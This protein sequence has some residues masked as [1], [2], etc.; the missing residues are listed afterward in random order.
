VAGKSTRP[1]AAA[2][3]VW[4]CFWQLDRTRNGNGWSAFRLTH[5]D[6]LDWSTLRRRPLIAWEIDAL[7]A[8]DRAR[9]ETMEEPEKALEPLRPGTMASLS[10]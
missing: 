9:L 2:E 3:R 7:L 1:P 5:S 8:M 10:Q 4:H 6:I